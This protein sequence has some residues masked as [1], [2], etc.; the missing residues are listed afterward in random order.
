MSLFVEE[1]TSNVLRHGDLK[2]SESVDLRLFV[3]EDRICFNLMDLSN[4]FDPTEY[5][6]M[7]KNDEAENHIGIRLVLKMAKDVKYYNTFNSNNLMVYMDRQFS[8]EA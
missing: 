6:E 8:A 3:S 4:Q 1:M 7:C 5:F 2:V